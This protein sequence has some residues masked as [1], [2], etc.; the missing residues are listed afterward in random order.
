MG[1]KI[2]FMFMFTITKH[3]NL[4]GHAVQHVAS[5]KLKMTV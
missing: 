4:N 1:K 2:F 3:K 5:E